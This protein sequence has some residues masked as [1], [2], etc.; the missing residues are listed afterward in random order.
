MF[1]PFYICYFRK[2]ELNSVFQITPGDGDRS[3]DDV[4]QLETL[5]VSRLRSLESD[6]TEARSTLL[7]TKKSEVGLSY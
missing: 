1:Y 7:E 6:L 4:E 3:S 5:L 2:Y